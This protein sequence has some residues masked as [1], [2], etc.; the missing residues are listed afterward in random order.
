MHKAS[1]TGESI[2]KIATIM[3]IILLFGIWASKCIPSTLCA[4]FL[5]LTGACGGKA[6]SNSARLQW[7]TNL[8]SFLK[9]TLEKLKPRWGTDLPCVQKLALPRTYILQMRKQTPIEPKAHISVN[10]EL[11]RQFLSP[12]SRFQLL[13]T[14]Q[15]CVFNCPHEDLYFMPLSLILPWQTL[16]SQA[17]VPPGT[18]EVTWVTG[19]SWGQQIFLGTIANPPDM[20]SS[21]F[22]LQDSGPNMV[23]V[24]SLSR[25]AG[26]LNFYL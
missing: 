7:P 14:T 10:V 1:N 3:Y 18:T 24:S 21:R 20:E 9:R 12:S 8:A 13:S 11:G 15:H 16:G 5:F 19:P 2:L 6:F 4:V 22:S 17:P 25:K 26:S 23:T